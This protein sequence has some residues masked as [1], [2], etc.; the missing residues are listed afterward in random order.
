MVKDFACAVD[1]AP[2]CDV[3]NVAN[4]S[5]VKA[6]ICEVAMPVRLAVAMLVSW[7]VLKAMT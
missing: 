5:V 1:S 6:A 3:V 7:S 2:I 4:L